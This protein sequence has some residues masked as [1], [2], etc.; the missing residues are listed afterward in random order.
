[1]CEKAIGS[2]KEDGRHDGESTPLGQRLNGQEAEAQPRV[3][4]DQYLEPL[5]ADVDPLALGSSYQHGNGQRSIWSTQS[6]IHQRK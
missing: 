3:L 2:Y 5:D 1:M 4:D 6:E